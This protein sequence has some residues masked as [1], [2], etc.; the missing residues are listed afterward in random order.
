MAMSAGHQ[1]P[2]NNGLNGQQQTMGVK[3][4][5]FRVVRG[6]TGGEVDSSPRVSAAPPDFSRSSSASQAESVVTVKKG[7]FV[8][9]KESERHVAPSSSC[10]ELTGPSASE[11]HGSPSVSVVPPDFSR[12]SPASQAEVVTVKKGR[13]VVR[14]ESER[15]VVPSPSREELTGPSTSEEQGQQGEYAA[16]KK[17]GRFVV[18]KAADGVQS[19]G[20][21]LAD[22][23]PVAQPGDAAVKKVG[24]FV[25]KKGA[26]VSNPPSR[27]VEAGGDIS[28]L[29][30]DRTHEPL[31]ETPPQITKKKGRFLVKTGASTND[32]A[33]D[34]KDNDFIRRRNSFTSQIGQPLETLGSTNIAIDAPISTA[35]KKGRFVVKKGNAAVQQELPPIAASNATLRFQGQIIDLP[36]RCGI[37]NGTGHLESA[38]CHL[39]SMRTDMIEAVKSINSCQSDNRMLLERNRELEARVLLLERLLVEEQN[40]RILAETRLGQLNIENASPVR[41]TKVDSFGM[42]LYID[43]S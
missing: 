40:L 37:V 14:K 15:Q 27:S 2:A 32:L 20:N 4:G 43:E 17:V 10:E 41:G 34:R 30:T 18:K 31:V 19:V 16:V 11:E 3:K 21:D 39:E 9:R 42:P 7:R 24:R 29:K 33:G 25:V 28:R 23:R 36:P 22:K 35:K 1:H 13:F 5:R 38:L 26:D 12:S 6:V 8:V